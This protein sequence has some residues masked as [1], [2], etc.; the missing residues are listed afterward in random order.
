MKLNTQNK[1]V[2]TVTAGDVTTIWFWN[3]IWNDNLL[4]QS[5][6]QL[7]SFAKKTNLSSRTVWSTPNIFELFHLPLSE[8]FQQVLMLCNILEELDIEA[9][10]DILVLYLG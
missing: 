7:H 3:D 9:G 1:G 10:H 4:S 6:P 5:W 2:A 8:A